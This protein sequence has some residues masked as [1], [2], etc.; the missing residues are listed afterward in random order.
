[1]KATTK[2]SRTTYKS[3][4]QFW[5]KLT[6]VSNKTLRTIKKIMSFDTI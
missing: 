6:T 4:S 2:I 1:L 3:T 5:H